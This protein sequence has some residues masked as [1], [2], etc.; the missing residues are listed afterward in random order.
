MFDIKMADYLIDTDNTRFNKQ[1]EVSNGE[2]GWVDYKVR[3]NSLTGL[4]VKYHADEVSF[5]IEELF[6]CIDWDTNIRYPIN[7]RA[8]GGNKI[9][10]EYPYRDVVNF[11]QAWPDGDCDDP[12]CFPNQ[13]IMPMMMDYALANGPF[14]SDIPSELKDELFTIYGREGEQPLPPVHRIA[15]LHF[16]HIEDTASLIPADFKGIVLV[17][18]ADPH[19]DQQAIVGPRIEQIA[20]SIDHIATW[21]KDK[22][23]WIIQKK[24]PRD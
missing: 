5:K 3:K 20:A 2:T 13:E 19:P 6:V 15:A 16:L 17:I 12:D 7:F 14:P 9:E 23:G 22:F 24:G 10:L 11:L 1:R 18:P 4:V 21:D 8:I